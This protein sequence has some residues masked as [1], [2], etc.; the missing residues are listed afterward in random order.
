MST[1]I[2]TT[3]C[4]LAFFPLSRTLATDKKP[5]NHSVYDSWNKVAG[6]C[7]SNDGRWI[8]YVTEP[9]SIMSTTIV[10]TMVVLMMLWGYG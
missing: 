9:Q 5:L 8:V 6:E 7:I 10:V 2:V 1:T 4:F 3:I